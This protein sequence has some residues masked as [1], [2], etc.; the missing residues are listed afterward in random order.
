M[1]Y[2]DSP[3]IQGHKNAEGDEIA[4]FGLHP[5]APTKRSFK[6]SGLEKEESY[7]IFEADFMFGSKLQGYK[8]S[9]G[10]FVALKQIVMV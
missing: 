5:S 7:S 8:K 2:R 9:F 4:G 6:E 3:V 10:I 1:Q